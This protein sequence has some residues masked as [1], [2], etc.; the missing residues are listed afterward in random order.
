MKLPKR[1]R[2]ALTK[3]E[4]ENPPTRCKNP[5]TKALFRVFIQHRESRLEVRKNKTHIDGKD[6][7]LNVIG[8]GRQ[9][10]A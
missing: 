1:M 2:D 5:T 8:K 7:R 10:S 9:G 3:E 4:L 6:C